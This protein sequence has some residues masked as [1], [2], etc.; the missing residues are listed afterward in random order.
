MEA[1][2]DIEAMEGT[3]CWLASYVL[4]SQP[5]YSTQ[6]HQDR[7]GATQS[8]L[9]ILISIIIQEYAPEAHP[10]ANP[11]GAVSQLRFSFPK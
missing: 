7:G 5:S 4:L 10:Q 2:T 8:E 6:D 3:P 9:S 11:L 1:G